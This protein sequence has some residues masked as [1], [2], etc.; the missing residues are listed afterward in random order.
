MNDSRAAELLQALARDSGRSEKGKV[1]VA[2]VARAWPADGTLACLVVCACRR[3]APRYSFGFP[4]GTRVATP[5]SSL[6]P[7]ILFTVLG[8]LLHPS[9]KAQS[10]LVPV[11]PAS[12]ASLFDNAR[13]THSGTVG[14]CL[15][16]LFSHDDLGTRN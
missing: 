4:L 16:P 13:S 5:C 11:L 8:G 6:K 10:H 2:V 12:W 3:L 15:D 14:H 7:A 9:S 1:Q